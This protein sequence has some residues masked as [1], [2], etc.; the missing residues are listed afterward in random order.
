M[1]VVRVRAER[2]VP[3]WS[4]VKQIRNGRDPSLVR[5]AIRSLELAFSLLRSTWAGTHVHG[6][7]AMGVPDVTQFVTRSHDWTRTRTM[8]C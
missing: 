8:L 7:A 4:P 3:S 5:V 2:V 6:R 1:L